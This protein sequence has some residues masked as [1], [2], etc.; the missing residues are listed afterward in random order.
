MKP[1][2]IL[3]IGG[4]SLLATT[5]AKAQCGPADRGTDACPIVTVPAETAVPG[6]S[7]GGTVI[8][9]IMTLF[10]EITPPNGFLV[11]LNGL[12]QQGNYCWVTDAGPPAQ[13]SG[14]LIGGAAGPYLYPFPNQMFVT[15]PG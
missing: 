7:M 8:G 9:G 15:P 3:L 6:P 10:N 5:P 13:G 14:F 12:G 2:A 1:A 4:L 11:A